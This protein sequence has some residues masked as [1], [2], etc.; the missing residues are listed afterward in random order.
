M[1]AYAPKVRPANGSAVAAM[2]CLD[3][4]SEP[5]QT[6]GEPLTARHCP[7]IN[8]RSLPVDSAI[9][10]PAGADAAQC[11]GRAATHGF[12]PPLL[13]GKPLLPAP[14]RVVCCCLLSGCVAPCQPGADCQVPSA[15]SCLHCG[16]APLE[17][18]ACVQT[19][20]SFPLPDYAGTASGAGVVQD[21]LF[22]ATLL[23][24]AEDSDIV[25]GTVCCMGTSSA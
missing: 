5:H 15:V 25:S 18:C 2:V 16:H 3:V 19:L 9:G 20:Q 17:M 21:P 7:T 1:C 12:L 24:T 11:Y 13:T 10:R 14:A 4:L 8:K 22:G 6:V 23:C